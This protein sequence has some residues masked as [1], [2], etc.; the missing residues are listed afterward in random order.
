LRDCW[1]WPL[2]F[3]LHEGLRG[4]WPL[5]AGLLMRSIDGLTVHGDAVLAF[6]HE[7]YV[8]LN[9]VVELFDFLMVSAKNYSRG[10]AVRRLLIGDGM[11]AIESANLEN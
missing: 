2:V 4:R 11:R 9:F 3:W 8:V 7:V 6:F 10:T 1:S 5:Y